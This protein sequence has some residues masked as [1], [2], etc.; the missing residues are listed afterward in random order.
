M[1]RVFHYN[2]VTWASWCLILPFP[3]SFPWLILKKMSKLRISIPLLRESIGNRWIPNKWPVIRRLFPLRD[4]IILWHR[5][6]FVSSSHRI[7]ETERDISYSWKM[8]IISQTTKWNAFSLMKFA[9]S[10]PNFFEICSHGSNYQYASIEL[11]GGLASNER[12]NLNQWWPSLLTHI[13]VTRPRWIKQ[14]LN[15]PK[16]TCYSIHDLKFYIVSMWLLIFFN[17]LAH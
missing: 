17:N 7:A 4:G 3:N 8:T 6:A 5:V 9:Y 2:D 13:C 12:T 16:D 1:E 15:I 11:D 14:I 10:Y